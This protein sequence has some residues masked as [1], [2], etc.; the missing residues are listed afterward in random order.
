MTWPVLLDLELLLRS[1]QLGSLSAAAR[2]LGLS[3]P[4]ASRRLA[5]LE[6][7]LDQQ[8]MVRTH[9]GSHLTKAGE[10]V[11]EWSHQL[12]D[13]ASQWQA[14]VAALHA[15]SNTQ[16]DIAASQTVAEYLAPRWLALFR[17]LHA[18]VLTRLE[19]HNSARVVEMVQSGAV[20]LGLLESPTVPA[21]LESVII[22]HDRLVVVVSPTHPW[23]R[24]R[25]VSAADL[26]GTP[27]VVRE[28]GSGTRETL[29]R[30]LHDREREPAAMELPSNAAVLSAAAAGA[31]PAVIS[32]L[33]AR[34]AITDGRLHRVPLSGQPLERELRA[35]W[36]VDT[37]L[38]HLAQQFVVMLTAGDSRD[39]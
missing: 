14:G 15:R 28:P 25:S 38:A 7:Q 3:Q 20:Q 2:E 27:L 31:G 8:L 4:E 26:A 22:G 9:T 23:R 35:A 33:A 17:S 19:V 37:P 32:G 18:D 6:G 39:Q 12:L 29:D 11:A 10:L 5:R 1:D 24:R 30:A 21:G 34:G 16:L 13:Q 36:S